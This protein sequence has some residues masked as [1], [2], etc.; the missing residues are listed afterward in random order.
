LRVD[1]QQRGHRNTQV[2]A[3]QIEKRTLDGGG[4]VNG[5]SGDEVR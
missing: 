2:F 5:D 1:T 4:G 3:E